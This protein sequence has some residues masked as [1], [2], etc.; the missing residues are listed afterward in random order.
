MAYIPPHR[1]LSLDTS[2]RPPQPAFPPP[3]PAPAPSRSPRPQSST[4]SPGR[5][6]Q[7]PRKD[8]QFLPSVDILWA[9]GAPR[10]LFVVV[11]TPD[12]SCD[13]EAQL[14][15]ARFEGERYPHLQDTV[16]YALRLVHSTHAGSRSSLSDL[17]QQLDF[18]KLNINQSCEESEEV[19]RL[20]VPW[21]TI[22]ASMRNYLNTA[23]E[24][25]KE[26]LEIRSDYEVRP[27]MA[28][29]L[30]KL[31][32]HNRI[33][34][35]TPSGDLDW[36]GIL[37]ARTFEAAWARR[38]ASKDIAKTFDNAV[39]S[40]VYTYLG[41]IATKD[42]QISATKDRYIIVVEDEMQPDTKLLCSCSRV[43][44]C[45]TQLANTSSETLPQLIL[46][47]VNTS[48]LRHMIADIACIGKISDIRL[49]LYSKHRVDLSTEEADALE[50]IV[51]KASINENVKGGLHWPLGYSGSL[52]KRFKVFGCWHVRKTYVEGATCKWVLQHADRTEFK[53][54]SGRR[55]YEVTL[56]PYI[57]NEYLKGRK[58]WNQEKIVESVE[59]FVEWVW[60]QCL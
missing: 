53:F 28:I 41:E 12:G 1:R 26:H 60:K 38:S 50:A 7:R 54:S 29:R 47:K 16:L 31:I 51:S 5:R 30:G 6:T 55:S 52:T 8:G 44:S 21:H 22:A 18:T 3:L 11:E 40:D 45:E 24:Q 10:C 33:R 35:S 14:E 59:G 58:E 34:G 17:Q 37:T 13:D 25:L 48:P 23:L 57:C 19:N 43:N 2:S 39:T 27:T 9:E 15:F 56:K 4:S 36:Y 42:S 20:R 46:E 32:F 49:A